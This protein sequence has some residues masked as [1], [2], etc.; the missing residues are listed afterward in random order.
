MCA[1]TMYN[2]LMIITCIIHVIMSL[3]VGEWMYYFVCRVVYER[4]TIAPTLMT[5]LVSAT[6]HGFYPAYYMCFVFLGFCT[7]AGRKVVSCM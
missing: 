6:W 1:M 5:Y 7:L 2:V 3:I 4:V